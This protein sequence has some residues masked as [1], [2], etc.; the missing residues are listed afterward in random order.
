MALKSQE[1]RKSYFL[2]RSSNFQEEP[3]AIESQNPKLVK[4]IRNLW[5]TRL[6]FQSH[7]PNRLTVKLKYRRG[8]ALFTGVRSSSYRNQCI[9]LAFSDRDIMLRKATISQ[10]EPKLMPRREQLPITATNP[11]SREPQRQEL[12]PP[13]LLQG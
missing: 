1:S 9:F 10:A 4:K 7:F 12:I 13:S 11:S 5:L 8:R 2:K 6:L 3:E